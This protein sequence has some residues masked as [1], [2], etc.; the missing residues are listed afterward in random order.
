MAVTMTDI[1]K[2]LNSGEMKYDDLI[3]GINQ[4]VEISNSYALVGR[5]YRKLE[6]PTI[7]SIC[8]SPA[9]IYRLDGKKIHADGTEFKAKTRHKKQSIVDT[10]SASQLIAPA[11]R[12]K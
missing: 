11:K 2:A 10:A 8:G 5:I 7:G 12:Q 4:G 6:K 1:L 3:N 9:R